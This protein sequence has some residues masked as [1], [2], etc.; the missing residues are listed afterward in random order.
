MQYMQIQYKMQYIA[1]PQV[2][3]QIYLPSLDLFDLE[4]V[5]RVISRNVVDV[6][7]VRAI[8]DIAN[9]TENRDCRIF[10]LNLNSCKP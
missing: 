10:A 8:W 9:L 7:C 5:M 2:N 6:R 4:L 3:K 1:K